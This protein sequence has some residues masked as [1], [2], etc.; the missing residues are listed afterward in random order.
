MRS[1]FQKSN[2]LDAFFESSRQQFSILK[3]SQP[4]PI[5]FSVIDLTSMETMNFKTVICKM[6]SLNERSDRADGFD[7]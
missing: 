6:N 1:K 2:D 3:K 4:H 5:F 7:P